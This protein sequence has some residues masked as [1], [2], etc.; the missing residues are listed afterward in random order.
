MNEKKDR[1]FRFPVLSFLV[2][3]FVLLIFGRMC[4]GIN[5]DI[6]CML[7]LILVIL[8]GYQRL[9]NKQGYR[10]LHECEGSHM[11]QISL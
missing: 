8:V 1:R 6:V 10:L 11:E 9:S 2:F 5:F 4:L 7:T 3:D